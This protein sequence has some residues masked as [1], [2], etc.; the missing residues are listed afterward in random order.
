LMNS[1]QA[2]RQPGLGQDEAVGHH[3]GGGHAGLGK[4]RAGGLGAVPEEQLVAPEPLGPVEDG[5]S[6]H[7][8]RLDLGLLLLGLDRGLRHENSRRV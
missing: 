4:S 6:G 1:M 3:L 5:L 8:Y 7:E 2:G